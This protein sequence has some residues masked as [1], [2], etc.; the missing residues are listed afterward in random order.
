MKSSYKISYIAYLFSIPKIVIE[1]DRNDKNIKR[2]LKT[3]FSYVYFT[4]VWYEER[5]NV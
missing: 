4:K 1:E 5:K 2:G 3:F